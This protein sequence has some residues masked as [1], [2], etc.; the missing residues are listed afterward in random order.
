MSMQSDGKNAKGRNYDQV[1]KNGTSSAGSMGAGGTG[2]AGKL[3]QQGAEQRDSRTDDLLAGNTAEQEA[4][5]GF[6]G[7]SFSGEI[8][9]GMEGIA[10]RSGSGAGNRQSGAQGQQG[11]E[12]QDKP[13][14]GRSNKESGG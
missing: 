12:S 1:T 3:D 5:Q 7:G 6:A 10:S 8:Q 11:P 2:D 4:E 14:A 13:A 9:T